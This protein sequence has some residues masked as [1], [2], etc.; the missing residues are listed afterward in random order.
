ML[1]GEDANDCDV[2]A[3]IIRQ[4]HPNLGSAKIVRINDPVR[5][6]KKTGRELATAVSTLVGKAKGIELLS[7]ECA[8]VRWGVRE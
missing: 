8:Q 2:L 3:S 4:H 7:V 1:A 5:L 6:K